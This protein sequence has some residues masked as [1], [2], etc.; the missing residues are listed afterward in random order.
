MTERSEQAV[1][2]VRMAPF[3][4]LSPSSLVM[5]QEGIELALTPMVA[6]FQ[7]ELRGGGANPGGAGLVDTQGFKDWACQP[8]Q[9]KKT[10]FVVRARSQICE[11]P[12]GRRGWLANKS[13]PLLRIDS[14]LSFP[15]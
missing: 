8:E 1:S 2:C 6:W 4:T 10:Q 12:A 7:A 14:K 13:I 3:L 11:Q 5:L 9:L 15:H